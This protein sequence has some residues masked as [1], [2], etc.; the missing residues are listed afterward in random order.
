MLKINTFF[1]NKITTPNLIFRDQENTGVNI[2]YYPELGASGIDFINK[3]RKKN[4]WDYVVIPQAFL[5]MNHK[6]YPNNYYKDFKKNI[7]MIRIQRRFVKAN[8]PL[9]SIVVDLT[10]LSENFSAFSKSRSKK[11][12]M[13]SF[14]TLVEQFA[15]DSKIT[16]KQA[17]LMI[18]NTIG[19]ERSMVESLAYFARLNS[20]KLRIKG[21]EGILLYGARKFWPMTTQESD[22]DGPY[23]KVNMNILS[24]YM[25]EVHGDEDKEEQNPEEEIK[26]TKEIVKLLY[27][28]HQDTLNKGTSGL[29]GTIKKTDTIEENP[30][31][32]IK[33]EIESNKHLRGKNFE[34]KLSNLFK[35]PKTETKSKNIPKIVKDINKDILEL[36]KRYNGTMVLNES[37]VL[38]S[39]KSFYNPFN[40]IGYND[41]NAYNKQD[42]EFGENLDQAIFDLIKSIE[43][44]KELNIKVLSIKIDITDTN[45]DRYKTYKIKLSH[46]DFGHEKP[47]TVSFHVPIPSKGKY[48]KLGGNDWIMINQ[49][50]PKPVVKVAPEMV[51]IYTH[52][53]TAAVFIKTHALNGDDDINDLIDGFSQSLKR[54]K[55]LKKK[56]EVLN[57]DEA[58]ELI[59]KYNL[60]D[61]INPEIF[62]NLEIK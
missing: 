32:L 14:I 34:D 18:D 10:P 30:L 2:I 16:S 35:E 55:K 19:D 28:T 6:V 26:N 46:K 9:K 3:Y 39:R 22:K 37:T 58:I 8:N 57:N 11:Q 7:P 53:N 49:F 12:T 20:N 60:P 17:Y 13:D 50:F 54:T 51:R 1:T 15:V 33:H 29:S 31:E 42:E 23:L 56:P 43:A 21:I 36:N 45:R 40:V 61:F 59:Q 27:K 24:R 48:L 25:K 47:Y 38:N 5:F 44:D 62:V 4:Y 52:Y 41:F